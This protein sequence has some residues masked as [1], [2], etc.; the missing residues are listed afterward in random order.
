MLTKTKIRVV[1]NGVD[2]EKFKPAPDRAGG[3]AAVW[4]GE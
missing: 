3:E 4:V 1:P 2:P